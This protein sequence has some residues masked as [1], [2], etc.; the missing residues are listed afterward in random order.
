MTEHE[1]RSSLAQL[2]TAQEQRFRSAGVAVRERGDRA[3]TV[4]ADSARGHARRRRA[5]STVAAVFAVAV[6][7]LAAFS[8]AGRGGNHTVQTGSNGGSTSTSAAPTP[9]APAITWNTP[10][11]ALQADQVQI[12]GRGTDLHAARPPPARSTSTA[13]RATRRP[14]GYTTLELTWQQHGVEMRM[15]IYFASDASRWWANEI[16]IYN[17]KAAGADWVTFDGRWFDSPLGQPYTGDLHLGQGRCLARHREP[18]TGGV[19]AAGH[20][21][22]PTRRL[23]R[24]RPSTRRSTWASPRRATAPRCASTTA[25]ARRSPT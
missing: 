16:R 24:C 23:T 14:H 1:P 25:P 13:T 19:R 21:R 8:L 22:R 17:G 20:V 5:V 4:T 3:A 11:V 6:V 2:S 15:N 18:P 7:S 12:A 10:T 9:T